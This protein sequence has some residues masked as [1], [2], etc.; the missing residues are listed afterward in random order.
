[1]KEIYELDVY[2]FDEELSDIIWYAYDDRKRR[3]K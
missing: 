1:M 3:N 2:K